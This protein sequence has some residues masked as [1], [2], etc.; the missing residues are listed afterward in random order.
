[1]KPED[2]GFAE[3][4][5]LFKTYCEKFR[6]LDSRPKDHVK[7]FIMNKFSL[8]RSSTLLGDGKPRCTKQVW[9]KRHHRLNSR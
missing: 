6:P 4:V 2:D 3:V 1:L 7:L 8:K 9:G 5:E